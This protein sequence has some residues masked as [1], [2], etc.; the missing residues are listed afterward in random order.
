MPFRISKRMKKDPSQTASL[1]LAYQ[2]DLAKLF[3]KFRAQVPNLIGQHRLLAAGDVEPGSVH[4]LNNAIIITINEPARAI[5]SDY[6]RKAYTKGQLR[7]QDLLSKEGIKDALMN[8]PADVR[9]IDAI[10]LRN[11]A[12]IIGVTDDMG[13]K[14]ASEL[15]DGI[16]KGQGADEIARRLVNEVDMSSDRAKLVA[17]TEV[18]YAYNN[19]SEARFKAHGVE[20]VEWLAALDERLCD[21]CNANDGKHFPIGSIEC[22]AHP[23]CR[24]TLLPVIAEVE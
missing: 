21:E 22:P 5:T 13:K 17:R 15:T 9:A 18:M 20:E 2:R 1:R 23:N 12:A 4:R 11:Y 6:A 14:I 24:C 7:A 10:R 16:V 19:A 3:L 8:T